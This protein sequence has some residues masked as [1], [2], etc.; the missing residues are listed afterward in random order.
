M[1]GFKKCYWNATV[2][3]KDFHE[4]SYENLAELPY[5]SLSYN[6][7]ETGLNFFMVFSVLP[8]KNRPL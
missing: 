2:K 8:S 5:V 1:A 6:T 4:E 3:L 7:T